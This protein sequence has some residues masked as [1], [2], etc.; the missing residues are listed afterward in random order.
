M[1]PSSILL[2]QTSLV[3]DNNHSNHNKILEGEE[4]RE[5][6]TRTINSKDLI[7]KLNWNIRGYEL[8]DYDFQPLIFSSHFTKKYLSVI[9]S[10]FKVTLDL[11][12]IGYPTNYAILVEVGRIS[13]DYKFS[14]VFGKIHVPRPDLILEDKSV[15]INNGKNSVVLEFNNTG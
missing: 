12:Q 11:A 13:E 7:E 1:I 4:L 8:L 6:I 2:L 15:D 3:L 10:G 14:H 9:P 5:I